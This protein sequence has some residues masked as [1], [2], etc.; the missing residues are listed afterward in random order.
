MFSISISATPPELGGGMVMMSKPRNWPR[1]GVRS[2]ASYFA[3]SSL[4]ISP[5]F[6]EAFVRQR[7]TT[8]AAR[9]AWREIPRVGQRDINLSVAQVHRP[10]RFQRRLLA[11]IER[12]CIAIRRAH[13]HETAAA[14]VSGARMRDGEGERG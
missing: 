12:G 7:E 4:V 13:Q 3:R 9:H 8:H 6:A 11:V 10:R 14:E 1:I 5:P 2:F